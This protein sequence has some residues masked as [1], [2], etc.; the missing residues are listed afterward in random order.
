MEWSRAKFI[1]IF[2]FVVLNGFLLYSIIRTASDTRPGRDYIQLVNSLLESKNIRVE[3][4]VPSC[5]A[6]SGS[7]VYKEGKVDESRV[8][9]FFLG[10]D[11]RQIHG[12]ENVWEAEGKVL[13]IGNNRIIFNDKSP[14][15]H[16]D[17][18]DREA[19]AEELQRVF[20]GIGL[21]PGD[22]I[23]DIWDEKDGKVYVRYV[24]KYKGQL[25]FSIHA[26]FTV[27]EKGLEHALVMTEEVSHT[28]GRSEVLSAW[29]LLAVSN[30]EENSVITDISFG[31]KR[32]HEGELYDSP[33]WRIRLSDGREIYYNAFTGEE[34]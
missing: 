18:A 4:T 23:P 12:G 16:L 21:K 10:R 5:R 26:D 14:D 6:E 24:R 34:I 2:L 9:S 31:F 29:R 15:G 33:V 32:I 13:E 22:F 27:S 1:L 20:R 17:I 25:L 11:A 19:L 28:I 30:L 3:C 8:V 7:I